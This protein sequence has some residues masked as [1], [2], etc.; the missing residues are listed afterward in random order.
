MSNT[1]GSDYSPYIERIDTANAN[2]E[3]KQILFMQ[4]SIF[5]LLQSNPL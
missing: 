1:L 2:Q 5:E 4:E 3:P